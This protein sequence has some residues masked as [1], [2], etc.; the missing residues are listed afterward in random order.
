[1]GYKDFK[2]CVDACVN[3]ATV[4]RYCANSCLKEGDLQMLSECI[5]TDMEC[6]AICEAATGM[7]VYD[8]RFAGDVCRICAQVCDNCAAECEKHEH[9]HCRECAEACRRC[10]EECRKMAA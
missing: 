9:D 6:A 2:A 10:A 7:M 4:C 1:M 3:C 5:R 8:S